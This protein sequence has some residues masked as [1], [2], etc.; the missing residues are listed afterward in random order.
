[1]TRNLR[2]GNRAPIQQRRDVD[3]DFNP[4]RN[5]ILPDA[6]KQPDR[7]LAIVMAA[8]VEDRL[9][10]MLKSKLLDDKKI[11]TKM[12]SGMGPLSNF[13]VKI[14]LGYLLGF[15]ADEFHNLLHA[16]RVVRNTYAHEMKPLDFNSNEIVTKMQPFE[17]I[18]KFPPR[19]QKVG[20][21]LFIAGCE[22]C[23]GGLYALGTDPRRF[24]KHVRGERV[25]GA[26]A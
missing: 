4:I 3:P 15:Y 14:D 6:K 25:T 7:S 22:F 5:I 23:F 20:R 10:E 18:N 24:Q 11:I 12:F 21:D 8:V 19:R 26:I 2:S 1:M 9:E 17:F 13:S 16:I